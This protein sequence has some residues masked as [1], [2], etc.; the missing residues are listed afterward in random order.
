IFGSLRAL[1][2]TDRKVFITTSIEH[3]AIREAAKRLNEDGYESIF[4]PND[5]DGIIDVAALAELLQHRA[6]EIA[7]VAVM[8]VNNETGVIQPIEKIA[9]LCAE[10]GVRFFT[11]GTQA[12]GKMPVDVS[13]LPIDLMSFAAH[14]F[15][16]PKG[17]GA[18]YIKP[19][20]K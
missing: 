5:G 16:G 20:T 2:G 10:H 11:D 8:W 19:R 18:L 9:M 15:H 13:S 7:L 4:L 1:S 17:A 3:S 14:K 6:K 12:V